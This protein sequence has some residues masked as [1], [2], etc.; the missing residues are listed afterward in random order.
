M[1]KYYTPT[2]EEFHV[3]FE[4]ES[5]YIS[6]SKD[7]EWAKAVLK[8]DLNNEDIAW[9]YTSYV[10]D[11][12]PTEFRVKHLNREDIE[13]EGFEIEKTENDGTIFFLYKK[14]IRLVK[15][16]GNW[17]NILRRKNTIITG[18]GDYEVIFHG[19]IKNKSEFKRILK[20]IGL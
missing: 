15:V 18:E 20:Q 1:E 3:G 9:F 8:E 13:G 17:V 10:G 4:F 2:I 19:E 12:V 16:D 14:Y 11:A 6:Y 5:N 7:G